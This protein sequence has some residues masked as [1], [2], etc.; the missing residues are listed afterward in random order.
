MSSQAPS[1]RPILLLGAPRSGTTLLQ[2][3]M[4]AHPRLAVPAENRWVLPAYYRRREFGDLSDP[5]NRDRLARFITDTRPAF[6]NFGLPAQLVRERVVDGPP[7]LGSGLET[8]MRCY[9]E[10]VGA[11]R[12]CDKRPA[13]FRHVPAL[14]RLFP[15][16]QFIHLIRDGRAVASSLLRTPWFRGDLGQA[17]GTW[18][19]A[20][21]D[22]ARARTM[23][24]PDRWLDV[25]FEDLLTD[26]EAQLRR[27]SAFLGEDFD[28][29]MLEP[30]TVKAQV[31]PERKTW[32][33]NTAGE[34][35]PSRI[36]AWRTDLGEADVDFL[37]VVAGRQLRAA[38]YRTARRRRP[39]D[40]RRV[41]EFTVR[42]HRRAS[43]HRR[44]RRRDAR[45][46]SR[47]GARLESL[48]RSPGPPR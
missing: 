8:V 27:L 11:D 6:N 16:A 44:N 32:H 1:D 10:R 42:Y 47:E 29:R 18:R 4:H 19:M 21:A 30:A 15:D 20:M 45:A 46:A 13:Y 40:A 3:M 26:P 36:E 28:A 17:I 35:L 9:A 37:E 33:A 31:V 12:W 39:A 38:G 2:L 14:L 43:W 22:T 34:L 48:Y 5:R 23:L 24:P 7:T 41:A 25:R